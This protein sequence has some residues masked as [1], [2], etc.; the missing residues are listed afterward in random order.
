MW[1]DELYCHTGLPGRVIRG[2]FVCGVILYSLIS[3]AD[4]GSEPSSVLVSKHLLN[5]DN[6]LALRMEQ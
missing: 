6:C 2:N 4:H 1:W 5:R 3:M